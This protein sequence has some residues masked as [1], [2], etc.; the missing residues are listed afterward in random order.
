M[1]VTTEEIHAVIPGCKQLVESVSDGGFSSGSLLHIDGKPGCFQMQIAKMLAE[2]Y[3]CYHPVVLGVADI[4]IRTDCI[5]EM[6][7]APSIDGSP[8]V[9]IFTDA[10]REQEILYSLLPYLEDTF[11]IVMA[12]GHCLPQAIKFEV[13]WLPRKPFLAAIKEVFR[14]KDCFKFEYNVS[15][16]EALF[17]ASNGCPELA[18][19]LMNK[20]AKAKNRNDFAMQVTESVSTIKKATATLYADISD[21]EN[22]S[23]DEVAKKIRLF[24]QNVP[25]RSAYEY[26]TR[27]VAMDALASPQVAATLG[28]T[29]ML[30]QARVTTEAQFVML[31]LELATLARKKV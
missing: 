24:V 17:S 11:S 21:V 30:M 18:V 16:G 19:A 27:E 15:S 10:D 6:L 9:A 28:I 5:A 23:I 2:A 25:W 7:R 20:C 13:N 31:C 3:G 12:D 8:K 14:I 22:Q 4:S 26:L 1:N 29:K